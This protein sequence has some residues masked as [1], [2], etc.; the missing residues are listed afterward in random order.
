MARLKSADFLSL[1]AAVI[2]DDLLPGTKARWL[3][4]CTHPLR[5]A[6][7][8]LTAEG[9]AVSHLLTRSGS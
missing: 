4:F 6:E 8:T 1:P 2:G 3:L 9:P 5:E 7:N